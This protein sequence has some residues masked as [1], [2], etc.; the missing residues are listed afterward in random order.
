MD[1]WQRE[2]NYTYNCDCVEKNPG[3]DFYIFNGK[4][5]FIVAELDLKN[6]SKNAGPVF[7]YQALLDAKKIT[8]DDRQAEIVQHLDSLHQNLVAYWNYKPGLIDRLFSRSQAL[9]FKGL[10]LWGGVGRGK[11]F[12]MDLFYQNL[13]GKRKLRLHFHRFMRMVHHGLNKASG[14]K[15]PLRQVARD[16]CKDID[17][18][19]FDEFFVT[20]IGDAMILANLLESLFEE[21]VIM[22]ATSNIEPV[23]LYERGLQRQKFLPAI[24]LLEENTRVVHVGG[25]TDYRLRSLEKAGTYHYPLTAESEEKLEHCFA[26]LAAGAYEKNKALDMLGR[27]ITAR[28]YA[29]GLAWFDFNTLCA[30]PR[31]AA[32]YIE[33]AQL[34]HTVL[35]SGVPLMD[36]TGDEQLRRFISLVDEFYD[37]HVRLIISAEVSAEALYTGDELRFPFQRTVSRLLEMQSTEY[38][39]H[40]HMPDRAETA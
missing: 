15:N 25:D 8:R 3:F 23:R 32:D 4:A 27:K 13:P 16:I 37:Q 33:I 20:E 1:I 19:C 30:G 31:S 34:C 11:T 10:Y 22:V 7:A 5:H 40:E 38:L 21:G 6:M 17:V 36:E 39:G 18:L 12:L 14:E 2:N 29:E 24:K 35:L 28:R 26:E 9:D